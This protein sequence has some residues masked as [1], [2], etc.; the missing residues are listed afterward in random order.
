MPRFKLHFVTSNNYD[1]S[2]Q[3][4]MPNLYVVTPYRYP[5]NHVSALQQPQHLV[6]TLSWRNAGRWLNAHCTNDRRGAHGIA[7][8]RL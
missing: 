8:D 3:Y 5:F 4:Q 2:L 7:A 1:Y 6:A